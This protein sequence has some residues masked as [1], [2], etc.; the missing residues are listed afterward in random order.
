MMIIDHWIIEFATMMATILAAIIGFVI[1]IIRLEGRVNALRESCMVCKQ[2]MT[3][4]IEKLSESFEQM[5]QKIDKTLLDLAMLVQEL[6]GWRDEF[7]RQTYK[8]K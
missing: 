8:E 5:D 4:H 2:T 6:R 1:W 7:V 3:T